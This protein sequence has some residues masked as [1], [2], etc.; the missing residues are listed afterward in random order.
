FVIDTLLEEGGLCELFGPSESGKSF[1]ALD[2]AFCIAAGVP[3]LGLATIAGPVVYIAAEG[4]GGMKKR[5]RALLAHYGLDELPPDLY[6]IDQA[7]NLMDPHSV[8][9]A[10]E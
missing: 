6:F 7:V 5:L 8:D 10:I 3:W 2:W 9:E 4:A 1:V